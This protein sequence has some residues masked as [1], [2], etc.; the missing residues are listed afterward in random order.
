MPAPAAEAS[1]LV[2]GHG[3][4]LGSAV[5][6]ELSRQAA[7]PQLA[8]VRW[9]S[10]SEGDDVAKAV[11]GVIE[12]EG[13]WRIYWC[14]G[15]G[16]PSTPQVALESELLT[17]RRFCETI[18]KSGRGVDGT[19]FF[20]SSAGALYSGAHQPPFTESSSVLPLAPYGHAKLDAE[21][22][23]AELTVAGVRVAIGRIA[24]L[25][26]PGQNLSKAQGL[27][28][29]LCLSI[30]TRRPLG[31]Y[32]PLDTLRDYLFADDAAAMVV[33]MTGRA[34]AQSPAATIKILASGRAVSIA[35][36]LGEFRLLTNRR[37]PVV[38]AAS[39]YRKIQARDL[40]MRSIVWPDID[41][42]DFTPLVVGIDACLQDIARRWRI[43][44]QGTR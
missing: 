23:V 6:R 1:T 34:A 20:A 33:E 28:S 21:R 18:A 24:N 30:Q 9:G 10:A 31:I 44:I 35:G 11:E 3:G 38:L 40:R 15:A 39:P 12:R 29:Q 13:R 17:F 8:K 7:V 41:R 27:I 43:G 42:R 5:C 37:P 2:F 36:L 26:G 19:V 4:L 32:V 25:Y 16:V 22:E 14:A